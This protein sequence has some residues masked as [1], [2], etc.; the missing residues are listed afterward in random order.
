MELGP[1]LKAA[2]IVDPGWYFLDRRG[3]PRGY[4]YI[5]ADPDNNLYLNSV[6]NSGLVFEL[7]GTFVGTFHK[8]PDNPLIDEEDDDR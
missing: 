4:V 7:K 1:P 8:V 5:S 3:P 6:N 2:D